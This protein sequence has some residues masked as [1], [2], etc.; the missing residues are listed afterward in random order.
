M[1][2]WCEKCGFLKFV[3]VVGLQSFTYSGFDYICRLSERVKPLDVLV[4][5]MVNGPF[6][7]GEF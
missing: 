4:S 3:P 7:R 5:N 2:C 1:M 6:Q